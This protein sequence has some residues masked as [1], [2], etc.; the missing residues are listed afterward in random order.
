MSVKVKIKLKG[1]DA[2][3]FAGVGETKARVSRPESEAPDSQFKAGSEGSRIETENPRE[4][5]CESSPDPSKK[6]SETDHIFGSHELVDNRIHDDSPEMVRRKN[7]K[8]RDERNG[9]RITDNRVYAD[10][11]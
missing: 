7:N 10:N 6:L 2:K 11:D 1:D 5:P 9:Y 4:Y 3:D 8:N